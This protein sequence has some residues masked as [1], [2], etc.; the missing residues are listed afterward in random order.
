M[1]SYA[2]QIVIDLD[3]LPSAS[4]TKELLIQDTFLNPALAL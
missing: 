1:I 4:N 3:H 2:Q